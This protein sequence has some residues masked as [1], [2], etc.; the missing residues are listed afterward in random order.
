MSAEAIVQIV[1]VA[2]SQLAQHAPAVYRAIV[3]DGRTVEQVVGDAQRAA[4]SIPVRPA[5]SALD[6]YERGER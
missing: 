5:G 4:H 3:G 1:G 2:L 6:A